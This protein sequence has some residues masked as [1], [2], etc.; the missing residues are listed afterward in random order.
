MSPDAVNTGGHAV[1]TMTG[2]FIDL[3]DSFDIANI[4]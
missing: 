3:F 4:I 1:D 2:L